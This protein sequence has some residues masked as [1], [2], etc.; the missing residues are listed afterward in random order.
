MTLLAENEPNNLSARVVV[1]PLAG[2]RG[3]GRRVPMIQLRDQV[4]CDARTLSIVLVP[5][6]G[7]LDEAPH[8]PCVALLEWGTGSATASAEV[9]FAKGTHLQLAA[10]FLS[11][12]ARN[13]GNLPDGAAGTVDPVPGPQEVIAMVAGYGGRV[14]FGRATRTF[15]F[16]AVDPRGAVTV[17]VP[18]FAKTMVVSFSPSGSF[19]HVDILDN[20]TFPVGG[21]DPGTTR[22][23]SASYDLA[24]VAV[25]RINL[26]AVASAVM[27]R[28]T[29]QGQI[30]F[31]QVAFELSL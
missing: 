14:A 13:D 16:R 17:P 30:A 21:G 12:A 31:L 11:I 20:M 10:S 7:P 2:A 9:D 8:G 22:G 3:P 5:A 4:D 18:N 27:V 15:Y 25:P 23:V 29:G 6:V 28:K 1:S 24:A 26:P 19:T